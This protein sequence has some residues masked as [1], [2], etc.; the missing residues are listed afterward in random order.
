MVS[1]QVQG[2]LEPPAYLARYVS[3]I[4]SHIYNV[5]YIEAFLPIFGNILADSG[6]LRIL[7]QLDIFV[8][9]QDYSEPLKYLASFG[10]Y[11]RAIHAYSGRYLDR[12]R[13]IGLFT[14]IGTY[15]CIFRRIQNP[16]ITGSNNVKQHLLFK[17]GSSFKSL[18]KFA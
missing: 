6:I 2:Y 15:F 14:H 7:A 12:F 16:G 9:I 17:S 10:H 11:S 8:Y 13:H 4:F 18:F 3:D 1:T 5:R